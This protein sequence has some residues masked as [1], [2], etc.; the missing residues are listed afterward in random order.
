MLSFTRFYM[1]LLL[2]IWTI[3]QSLFSL[4]TD[5]LYIASKCKH[6]GHICSHHY[7]PPW[8]Y[9]LYS[10]GF[11]NLIVV[12]WNDE[13]LNCQ[14]HVNCDSQM[15][16]SLGLHPKRKLVWLMIFQSLCQWNYTSSN[17]LC[18]HFLLHQ[19]WLRDTCTWCCILPMW[20]VSDILQQGDFFFLPVK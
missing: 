15:T 3:L 20:I 2:T 5:Y 13:K 9:L 4:N 1:K 18:S 17:L 14:V 8:D 10:R 7:I 12:S 19:S 6:W 11:T 16:A